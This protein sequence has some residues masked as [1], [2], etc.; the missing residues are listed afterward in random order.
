MITLPHMKKRTLLKTVLGLGG[1]SA[2][3]MTSGAGGLRDLQAQLLKS[4]ISEDSVLAKLKQE[5]KLRVGYSQTVPWFQR[6]AKSGELS[7]I[8]HDVMEDLARNLEI[9]VEYQEVSWA[10]ATVGLRKGDYD[11]FA[12]SLFYTIPRALVCNYVGPM[13]SK[14]RLIITRKDEAHRFKSIDD[15]NSSNVT[16]SVNVGAAEE[17]WIKKTFPKAKLITTTGQIALSAEPV[18]TGK[19]DAWATGEE[20]A[21]VFAHKNPWAHIINADN[22]TDRNPNTWAI[23]YGDPAWNAFLH[24]WCEKMVVSGYVEDRREYYLS[25]IAKEA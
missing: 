14:G 1:I 17:D 19:A 15:L 3:G 23:R 21:I 4:G 13:W 11:V 16:F 8:Y 6:D 18:R 10:N 22:P 12:S 5:N 2:L 7:G 25:K 20:D 9:K 24:M